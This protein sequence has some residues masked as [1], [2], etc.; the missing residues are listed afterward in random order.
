MLWK[1]LLFFSIFTKNIYLYSPHHKT[2]FLIPPLDGT[3]LWVDNAPKLYQTVRYLLPMKTFLTADLQAHHPC[4]ITI[5]VTTEKGTDDRFYKLNQWLVYFNLAS[6][7]LDSHFH[8]IKHIKINIT[9][10]WMN[11]NLETLKNPPKII[12]L[13][14]SVIPQITKFRNTQNKL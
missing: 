3:T 10:D 5:F 12:S 4:V 8:H 14:F 7:H 11:K 2:D 13:L 6:L 9:K 1:L